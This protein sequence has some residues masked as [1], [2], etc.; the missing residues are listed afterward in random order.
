[1]NK[2][3]LCSALLFCIIISSVFAGI[4]T[5][6]QVLQAIEDD[7]NLYRM[8]HDNPEKLME[9]FNERTYLWD[10]YQS[11]KDNPP[12][13]REMDLTGD[14]LATFKKNMLIHAIRDNKLTIN[15]DPTT[16]SSEFKNA[17]LNIKLSDGTIIGAVIQNAKVT[18][19][20][21]GAL[22]EYTH[23]V[24][25][26]D[27]AQ[28]DIIEGKSDLFSTLMNKE[29]TY[30]QKEQKTPT[31]SKALIGR[32]ISVPQSYNS[33]KS[34]IWIMIITGLCGISGILYLKKRGQH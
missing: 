29:I 20:Q 13:F 27:K 31:K 12:S 30:T 22:K 26:S 7:P 8:Y 23:S 33:V 14:E 17:K 16:F 24:H 18:K 3:F 34:S 5:Q 1:M 4:P 32:A 25:I 19:L 9:I 28:N 10:Y 6:E 2:L 11:V 15:L 21:I